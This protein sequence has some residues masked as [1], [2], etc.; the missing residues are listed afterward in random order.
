MPFSSIAFLFFYLPVTVAAYFITPSRFR[1]YLLLAASLLLF[2]WIDFV[3]FMLVLFL[4]GANHF[5][6]MAIAHARYK[7]KQPATA[8]KVGLILNVLCCIFSYGLYL[9]PFVSN[10]RLQTGVVAGMLM[11]MG[12]SIYA[13]QG[14]SYLVFVYRHEGYVTSGLG[15]LAVYLSFFPQVVCGPIVRYE[16][17]RRTLWHRQANNHTISA[18]Y[19]LFIRGLAK[20]IFL[21]DVMMLLWKSVV[22]IDYADMPLLTAWIGIIAF[23]YAMYYYFSG[24]TDMARGLAKILG[25]ELPKNFNYPYLAKNVTD[26]WRRWNISLSVW[27]KAYVLAPLW[28][29]A[30]SFVLILLKFLFLCVLTGIWYGMG[31]SFLL[32]GMYLGVLIIVE[33]ILILPLLEKLPV[34]IQKGYFLIAIMIGWVIFAHS[35]TWQTGTY[36]KAMFLGNSNGLLEMFARGMTGFFDGTTFYFLETYWVYLILCIVAGTNFVQNR[37]LKLE[38]T[39]PEFASILRIIGELLLTVLCLISVIGGRESAVGFL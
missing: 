8:L 3:L 5:S 28:K 37:M 29:K 27:L 22:Q 18:G 35:D 34:W 32:W 31:T 12:I 23:G 24:Y 10:T 2:F 13:L 19:G 30:D 38:L 11:P 4:I 7:N 33:K 26:F 15:E 9:V 21:A 39:K 20:K 6:G 16:D 1:N 17:I 14:I 36:I 25:F